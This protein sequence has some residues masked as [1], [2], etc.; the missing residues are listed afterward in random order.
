VDL[1]RPA[2][3]AL[4]APPTPEQ[5]PAQLRYALW[6]DRGTR[7]GLVVL[8]TT[9]GAYLVGWLPSRV[10]VHELSALWHLPVDQFRQ[11][12]GAPLGWGWLAQLQHGDMAALLGIALLASCSLP[13]LLA[14]V[15]LYARAGDRAFTAICLAQVAVLLFAASGVLTTGH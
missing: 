14:L 1:S 9:L 12:T 10:P 5:P 2:P 8:V 11:T 4:D 7:L 15:P 13:C 6:L 3:T